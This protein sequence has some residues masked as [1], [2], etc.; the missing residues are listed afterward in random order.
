MITG[1]N[2]D[3]DIVCENSVVLVFPEFI[4]EALFNKVRL[5][6][7]TEFLCGLALESGVCCELDSPE[8]YSLCAGSGPLCAC[9]VLSELICIS[10]LTGRDSPSNSSFLEDCRTSGMCVLED[11]KFPCLCALEDVESLRILLEA[12]EIF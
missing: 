10:E 6:S 1:G 8:G 9:M 7:G 2:T 4:A 12:I 3:S 11:D 5:A